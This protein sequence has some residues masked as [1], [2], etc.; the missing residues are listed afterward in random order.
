[1]ADKYRLHY[2]CVGGRNGAKS[3]GYLSWTFTSSYKDDVMICQECR[4][5]TS[6]YSVEEVEPELPKEPSIDRDENDP[7]NRMLPD[8]PHLVLLA[9]DW[10]APGVGRIY[11]AVRQGRFDHARGI[12]D[13]LERLYKTNSPQPHKDQQHAHSVKA[14][15]NDMEIWRLA[16][17]RVDNSAQRVNSAPEQPHIPLPRQDYSNLAIDDAGAFADEANLAKLRTCRPPAIPDE[18]S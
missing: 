3:H 18:A 1:M 15:C 4:I 8:E 14:V 7:L 13:A 10:R 16:H 9:R 17:M 11:A 6:P 5:G 2:E 12:L